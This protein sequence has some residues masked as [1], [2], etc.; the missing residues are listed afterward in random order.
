MTT[1]CPKCN[2]E[3]T[4]SDDPAI[5]N[6]QCP[7]CGIV[8][9]KFKNPAFKKVESPKI[10]EKEKP[11]KPKE[12]TPEEIQFIAESKKKVLNLIKLALVTF[13][14][15]F[16]LANLATIP[17]L[18]WAIIW[19]FVGLYASQKR[20]MSVAAG[21]LGGLV[22]GPLSLYMFWASG[23]RV[24][25]PACAEWIKK[26]AEICPHCKTSVR[27][28]KDTSTRDIDSGNKTG[29]WAKIIG[30]LICILFV[31]AMINGGSIGSGGSFISQPTVSLREYQQ[32]ANGMSYSDVI[33]IIGAPGTESSRNHMDGVPGVMLS[34]DTVSYDWINSDGSNMNAMFQNGS[35]VQ[36]AQ[37][38]L[39]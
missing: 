16:Y 1:I 27:Q 31:I 36:K 32:I 17:S 15:I 19:P 34:I 13:F 18:A 28:I 25:C 37:F 30:G 4:N 9:R 24:Q 10:Q 23:D 6:Y 20:G 5:P 33:Q 14:V 3:R 22:L 29:E 2:Y 35:L 11:I 12:K 8:Y 21:L 38:G 26:K 39:K 7:A